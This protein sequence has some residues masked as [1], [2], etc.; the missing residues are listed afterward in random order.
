MRRAFELDFIVV[1]VWLLGMIGDEMGYE[2]EGGRTIVV[3]KRWL[4]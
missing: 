3:F 1:L 4:S 2:M